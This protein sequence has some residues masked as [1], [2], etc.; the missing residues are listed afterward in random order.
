MCPAGAIS[1]APAGAAPLEK[2]PVAA[3]PENIPEE[4]I[5]CQDLPEKISVAI[6]GIGGQGNLFFGRVLTRLAF[7]AGYGDTNVVKGETH[8]MAQLG[9]PVISTFSCGKVCSPVFLPGAAD[10]LV[11]MEMGE[12]LRPGFLGLLKPGGTLL[13]AKTRVI[14]YGLSEADYP[15]REQIFSMLT[16]Y[17]VI[18][19]DL[20]ETSSQLGDA[21]GR[22]A[23]VIMLGL[24]SMLAPFN[25]MPEAL[26][27]SALRSV[28]P[29]PAVFAANQV[30]FR[31]GRK[32]LQAVK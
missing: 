8:G 26:W 3:P 17:K 31:A 22:A 27:L 18:E 24:L 32:L 15:T 13:L 28:N 16:G 7:L 1:V 23:N 10:C 29:Q 4:N 14:P 6:R 12:V 19:A 30:A 9:G 5:V 2:A 25:R 21:S 11:S 20:L